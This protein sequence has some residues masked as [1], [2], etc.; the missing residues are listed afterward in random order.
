MKKAM[1]I[2]ALVVALFTA[3]VILSPAVAGAEESRRVEVVDFDFFTAEVVLMDED[4]YI[5]TCP[6]GTNSWS[7]GE[8]Y[9]L[10]IPNEG[11]PEIREL[12]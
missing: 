2:T 3:V 10:Y 4:G 1:I 11:E 9:E 12:P 8:E 7:P 5:W 6:F